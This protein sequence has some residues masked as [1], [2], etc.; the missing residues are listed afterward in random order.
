M[1]TEPII[2]MEGSST[3]TAR[4]LVIQFT[5]DAA[6]LLASPAA[7]KCRAFGIFLDDEADSAYILED[8][9]AII[10]EVEGMLSD[11]GYVVCWNDGY[12][13]REGNG[14]V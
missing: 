8:E 7:K 4:E 9:D 6:S 10:S 1:D 2:I 13:I 11:A 3:R 5:D 12:T 14:N